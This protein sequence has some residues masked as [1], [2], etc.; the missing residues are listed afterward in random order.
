MEESNFLKTWVKKEGKEL[1]LYPTGNL[2]INISFPKK[3]NALAQLWNLKEPWRHGINL[4]HLRS[5]P[6]EGW[7]KQGDFVPD[8]HQQPQI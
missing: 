2:D 4:H 1:I 3:R 5:F 7:K 8:S 6:V